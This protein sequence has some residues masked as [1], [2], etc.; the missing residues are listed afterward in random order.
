MGDAQ[1]GGPGFLRHCARGVF[2][3]AY[4]KA[5]RGCD[6]EA[7]ALLAEAEEL[8]R[9]TDYLLLEDFC[10]L[11]RVQ[12]DLATG[13]WHGLGARIE[14]LL[15]NTTEPTFGFCLETAAAVLDTAQGRAETARASLGALVTDLEENPDFDVV[16]DAVVAL[17]RLDLM[18]GDA[19]GAWRRLGPV[20]ALP[21]A[22]DAALT[23]GHTD[24]A[25][26]LTEDAEHGIEGLTAPGMAGD[27]Q[28]ARGLLTAAPDPGRALAHL[29]RA[30]IQFQ[31]IGRVHTAARI[32]ER[33]GRLRLATDPRRPALAT[34]D[35]REALDV[36]TR[37]G[38]TQDALNC[39]RALRP[40]ARTHPA[41][42]GRRGYGDALSPREQQVAE[43]LATG[44]GNRDIAHALGLSPRTVEHHVARTLRKL[45]VTRDRVCRQPRPAGERRAAGGPAGPARP[46]LPGTGGAQLRRGPDG[47]VAGRRRTARR[48]GRRSERPAVGRWSRE[49]R[50]TMP[51]RLGRELP[52]RIGRCGRQLLGAGQAE[53]ELSPQ[54]V[55]APHSR[56][57]ASRPRRRPRGQAVPGGTGLL[58]LDHAGRGAGSPTA[59]LV[60]VGTVVQQHARSAGAHVHPDED[61]RLVQRDGQRGRGR[62]RD[63]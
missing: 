32:T 35:L 37:L 23:C 43:L 48:R 12:L 7:A 2:N 8:A 33:I 21:I 5:A 41:E 17:A 29:D 15:R 59:D 26:Q 22:V 51:G 20:V 46:A 56:D 34:H 39:E 54:P 10:R 3:A 4:G 31:A 11:V 18:A 14:E 6:D 62:L 60:R 36:F 53:V 30:R 40:W 24:G 1:A 27:V 16:P 44:A 61:H 25:R 63:R 50:R 42:P 19:A 13:R 52:F 38:A 9:R 57:H 55:A 45:G 28:W 47:R 58:L 49:A